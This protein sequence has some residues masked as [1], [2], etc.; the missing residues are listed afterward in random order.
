MTAKMSVKR[1]SAKWTER[2]C[3]KCHAHQKNIRPMKMPSL[4]CS[5]TRCQINGDTVPG[6]TAIEG[7]ISA[8]MP[9]ATPRV[10]R[11]AYTRMA[12][13]R[14]V[15]SAGGRPVKPECPDGQ[16]DG[17]KTDEQRPQAVPDPRGR[18]LPVL[19]RDVE[20]HQEEEREDR[21]RD[22]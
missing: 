12:N 1:S 5:R 22:E 16:D 4:P 14:A 18:N 13:L 3:S 10:P 2:R 6:G 15:I 20:V 19:D 7:L 11:T 9:P 8:R 21:S 17:G